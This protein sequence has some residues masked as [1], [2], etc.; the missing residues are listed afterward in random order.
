LRLPD[1]IPKI[2]ALSEQ[3]TSS[4]FLLE[5][6]FFKMVQISIFK[7]LAPGEEKVIKALAADLFTRANATSDK[8]E[9]ESMR[10]RIMQGLDK[11][12]M[13]KALVNSIAEKDA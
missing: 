7:Q 3:S 2:R 1:W 12:K 4:K 5:L 6:L 8:R 13:M 10:S 9:R 11:S